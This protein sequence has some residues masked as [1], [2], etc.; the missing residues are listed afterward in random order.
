MPSILKNLIYFFSIISIIIFP[1]VSFSQENIDEELLEINEE[2]A[3]ESDNYEFLLDL[4]KNPIDINR[5][6]TD[7]LMI[8]PEMRLS[9]ALN[10]CNY[11]DKVGEYSN[12]DEVKERL[13]IDD[14]LFQRL[15]QFV[16]VRKIVKGRK[17]D[18]EVRSRI[19]NPLEKSKGFIDGKYFDSILKQY[20]RIIFNY[21]EKVT[22]GI[23]FEKD[24]GEKDFNDHQSFYIEL[25][26]ILKL[27]KIALGKYQI[28]FAEGLVFWNPYGF[29]KV[30]DGIYPIKKRGRGILG[31]KSSFENGGLYGISIE[32]ELNLIK[33]YLFCSSR[34]IDANENISGQITS[35]FDSGLHRSELELSKKEI[36]N[37]NLFGGRFEFEINKK[38]VIGITHYQSYYNKEFISNERDIFRFSGK[39]CNLSA[40]DFNYYFSNVNLFGEVARSKG[41]G[42]G[43]II[44]AVFD[45]DNAVFGISV[46]SYDKNFYS[47]YGRGF[48]ERS[49]ENRN[50]RG[51][52]LGLNYKV[53]SKLKV[54]TYFDQFWFPWR[55][56][57]IP[58]PSAG[59]DEM[60]RLS[61]KKSSKTNFEVKI[62]NNKED[63]NITVEDDKGNEKSKIGDYQRTSM[64]FQ[65]DRILTQKIRCRWRTEGIFESKTSKE[66]DYN[67]D[68]S[69]KGLL[70]YL[71]I[72]INLIKDLIIDF[73]YTYFTSKKSEILFYQFEG[74]LPGILNISG[75]HGIG[76][77]LYLLVKYRFKSMLDFALKYSIV[78]YPKSVEI[79][80][81]DDRIK[82]NVK[83]FFS[84]QV[85][86]NI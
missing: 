60:V 26:D 53:N 21:D 15:K 56:Y 5:I 33:Y 17:I 24:S 35:I 74:D 2:I 20:N 82:G 67:Y 71:D 54:Y 18:F 84:F 22:G 36:V 6:T 80:S 39:N 73:R 66:K 49:Y 13:K 83:S 68:D 41:G 16:A 72:E 45:Y 7:Q 23:L 62:R 4:R 12:L 8:I 29:R 50:E 47:F 11:R 9:T 14:E 44:G 30:S 46:R 34:D 27:K 57:F 42:K 79:G 3:E 40:G 81:G 86:I 31:Y 85:E 52:Y 19:I 59:C 78:N 48:S 38:G 25:K 51:I 10:I 64:R 43:A 55:T 75:F 70:N 65:V 77:E 61:Y 37:E 32:G 1:A 58:L 28:E 76:N 69:D 63:T